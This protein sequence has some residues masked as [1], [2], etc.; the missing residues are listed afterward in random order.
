M[1]LPR[2]MVLMASSLVASGFQ[3]PILGWFTQIG[4]IAAAMSS[5]FS[6]AAEP[7]TACSAT[8]LLVTFLSIIPVGLIWAQLE[9]V[10]LRKITVESEHAEEEL[11]GVEPAE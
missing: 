1:T 11:A 6:V 8:L 5:F 2:C 3:L 7:A 10:S 4:I 9:H